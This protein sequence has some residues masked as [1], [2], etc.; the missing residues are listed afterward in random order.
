LQPRSQRR[1]F[2]A[3][4]RCCPSITL[5]RFPGVPSQRLQNVFGSHKRAGRRLGK[6]GGVIVRPATK[7]IPVLH[8]RLYHFLLLSDELAKYLVP[9]LGQQPF[10]KMFMLDV[11]R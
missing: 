7:M 8:R 10:S 5:V 4:H 2:D 9:E 1:A 6:V 11:L 3:Q